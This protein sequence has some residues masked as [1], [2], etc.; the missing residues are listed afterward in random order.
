MSDLGSSLGTYSVLVGYSFSRA[1]SSVWAFVSVY[2]LSRWYA[3]PPCLFAT[4]LVML[5]VDCVEWKKWPGLQKYREHPSSIGRE[6]QITFLLV[7]E[8]VWYFYRV[9]FSYVVV[10]PFCLFGHWLKAIIFFLVSVYVW[11]FSNTPSA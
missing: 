11:A 9:K 3:Y 8:I 2:L 4:Y 1:L 10:E 6:S 7:D 5:C